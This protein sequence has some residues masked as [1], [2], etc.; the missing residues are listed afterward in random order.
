[1]TD[2]FKL[3]NSICILYEDKNVL[4]KKLFSFLTEKPS[5]NDSKDDLL[6]KK[7]KNGFAIDPVKIFQL[8]GFIHQKKC[9]TDKIINTDRRK[10]FGIYYTDYSIARLIAKESL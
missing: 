2:I 10:H 3:Y 6:Y 9:E 5:I 1:M 8:V 4:I 7:L